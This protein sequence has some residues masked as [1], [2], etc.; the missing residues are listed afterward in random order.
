MG[1]YTLSSMSQQT[2]QALHRSYWREGGC[3]KETAAKDGQ[4]AVMKAELCSALGV[5]LTH[6]HGEPGDTPAL[7]AGS[8]G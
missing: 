8:L 5:G 2:C 3:P 7:L 6:R 1:L 4:L